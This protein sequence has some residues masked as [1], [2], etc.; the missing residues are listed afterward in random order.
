[1]SVADHEI[2]PD[3]YEQ[4]RLSKGVR[5]CAHCEEGRGYY[6]PGY[7]FLCSGCTEAVAPIHS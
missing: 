6:V 5:P 2:D 3:D 7:G 1:M 4:R